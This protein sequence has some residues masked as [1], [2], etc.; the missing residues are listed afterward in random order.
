MVRGE[1]VPRLHVDDALLSDPKTSAQQDDVEA[2]QADSVEL[3][4]G[5]GGR[6]PG[7]CRHG[8]QIGR[9]ED[10]AAGGIRRRVEVSRDQHGVG[11]VAGGDPTEDDSGGPHAGLLRQVEV[12]V[13]DAEGTAGSAVVKPHPCAD[14]FRT[15]SPWTRGKVG[16]LFEPERT[17]SDLLKT[18]AIEV[19]RA[20]LA[21]R[22]AVVPSRSDSA[23]TRQGRLE[24]PHL[25]L[26]CL[27]DTQ[28]IGPGGQDG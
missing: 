7:K 20:M 27:L 28:D 14:P 4:G 19:D 21:C 12:G 18:V 6:P 15:Q 24:E 11:G 23:V 2:L 16:G 3:I 8:R 17:L 5:C 22:P 26:K 9:G 10:P 13:V 25:P 1:R